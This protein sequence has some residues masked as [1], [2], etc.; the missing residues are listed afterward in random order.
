M[1]SLVAAL[2]A[3]PI[4]GEHRNSLFCDAKSAISKAARIDGPVRLDLR[5]EERHR[6]GFDAHAW[7][8]Q[9]LRFNG[10]RAGSTERVQAHGCAVCTEAV[11][12]VPHQMGRE[13]QNETVPIV[14][15]AVGRF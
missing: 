12:V 6:M 10:S 2:V 5:S 13:G 9:L 8:A 7:D 15:G 3:N 1:Y 4:G 14:G 11:Q